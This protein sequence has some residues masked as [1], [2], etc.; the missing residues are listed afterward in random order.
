MA[1]APARA[2]N[3]ALL[4]AARELR[5]RTAAIVEANKLRPRRGRRGATAPPPSSIA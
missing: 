2:K 1:L 3:A 4:A 5:A